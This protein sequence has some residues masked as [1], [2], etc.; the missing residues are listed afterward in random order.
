MM[1]QA[2]HLS[3]LC[4]LLA[5][6]CMTATPLLAQGKG[7]DHGKGHDKGHGKPAHAVAQQGRGHKGHE[8]KGRD[9]KGRAH[10]R[11][12]DHGRKPAQVR[13]YDRDDIRASGRP[14]SARDRVAVLAV[15]RADERSVRA[16]DFRVLRLADR[17]RIENRTGLVLVD[18]DENRARTLG[19]WNVRPVVYRESAGAPAFCRSGAG[20]PVWG[21]QWCIDKGFGLGR[22]QN[23][24]WGYTPVNDMVIRPVSSGSLVRDA[25]IGVLGNVVFDRLGLHAVT[26]GYTEPLTGVWLGE[27][28]GPRVLRI[29][30]GAYPVAEIVDTNRDDRPELLVVALRP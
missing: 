11:N 23:V 30:S 4:L 9:D 20:H 12:D 28:T 27:P 18:L 22:Y 15:S 16:G 25:L 21:R 7:K 1:H 24:R 6:L 14:R 19:R 26:L 10:E 13:V 2:K 17:V 5:A 29:S 8:D 3:R